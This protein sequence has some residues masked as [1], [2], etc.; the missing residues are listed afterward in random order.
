[1]MAPELIPRLKAVDCRRCIYWHPSYTYLPPWE[2][3]RS[4]SPVPWNLK[5]ES[6]IFDDGGP[7]AGLLG[8]GARGG[9]CL[10]PENPCGGLYYVV[11]EAA[12]SYF[13]II[14]SAHERAE[15]I[16]ELL[17]M[18]R[19]TRVLRDKTHRD[20]ESTKHPLT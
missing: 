8:K 5:D 12:C 17:A 15:R 6:A 1:M 13:K 9:V 16:L 11:P 14:T 4:S 19:R 10:D 7:D 18:A 2:M 20:C 3:D